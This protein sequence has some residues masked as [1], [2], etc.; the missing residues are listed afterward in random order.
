MGDIYTNDTAVNNLNY[1]R[2]RFG[3]NGDYYKCISK[4]LPAL[5]DAATWTIVTDDPAE[6]TGKTY[7]GKTEG[8]DTFSI[9]I[10]T[11]LGTTY[12]DLQEM[13][14]KNDVYDLYFEYYAEGTDSESGTPTAT[15]KVPNCFIVSVKAQG[16]E[17]NGASSTE[18][19]FQP[20]GGGDDDLVALA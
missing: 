6:K 10:P 4:N 3:E 1:L 12:G 7:K 16:G 20:R 9:V 13:A 18:I 2:V 17:N 19:V 15:V 5:K 14:V 11:I 8:Y